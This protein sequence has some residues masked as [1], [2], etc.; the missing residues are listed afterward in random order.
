MSKHN[1]LFYSSH[2]NDQLSR[3][4]L[5]ELN[6]NSLLKEQ[7]LTVCVNSPGIQLPKIITDKNEVPVIVT[8]G[9]DKPI[10]GEAAL[11]LIREANSGKSGGLDYGDPNKANQVSEDH[12]I[13]ANEHD[14]TSY[15]QAFNEGW[16]QGAENDDR[17]LNSAF[18]PIEEGYQ[19]N[20]VDTY[21]EKGKHNTK[22]LKTQL[23]RKFKQ[24]NFQRMKEVPQ[25]IQ[26]TG[27]GGPGLPL[28]S[29]QHQHPNGMLGPNMGGFPPMHQPGGY[30]MPPQ[31]QMVPQQQHPFAPP[32]QIPSNQMGNLPGMGGRGDM[33]FPPQPVSN[34]LH[35]PSRTNV[36]QLPAG[37][38]GQGIK[39]NTR[40]S[41]ASMGGSDFSSF[42]SAFSG[43]SLM[44][45]SMETSKFG[46]REHQNHGN[47]KRD[48]ML[49]MGLPS[50]RGH[51]G[52]YGSM[53]NTSAFS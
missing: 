23:D 41:S 24:M 8:R 18:S 46:T 34:P 3:E 52:P 10:S 45:T 4:I 31:A 14:R 21:E 38:G 7:Y 28:A 37:F 22:G 39:A 16:N 15:H 44:G 48:R 43:A 1:I 13:L 25:A 26:R 19:Q 11:S 36:P 42:D 29:T 35:H 30:M 53:M 33:R 20:M 27:A 17:V 9:F 50:G 51:A 40:P 12:G 47:Q 5:Q 32:R 49:S 2:P 6:R